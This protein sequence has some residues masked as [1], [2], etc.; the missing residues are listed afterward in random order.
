MRADTDTGGELAVA[1]AETR[2]GSARAGQPLSPAVVSR[3]RW[4]LDALAIVWLAWVYDIIANLAPLRQR[5]AV[6][7]ALDVLHL[8]RAL[9]LDP[10]LALNRWLASHHTLALALSDYYDNAHFIVTL[11]LL[12]WLWWRRADIYRPLRNALVLINVLG[13]AVFWLYP[14]APPRMLAGFSDVV[15]DSHAFGSWHTG[16]LA[17]A[18][19]Q[20]AAM[21]S[22]HMAWAA[23]CALVIWRLSSS[24]WMRVVA[25]MYP[26]LTT[27]AVLATGNHFLLDIFAGLLTAALAVGLAR[28]ADTARRSAGTACHKLVTKSRIR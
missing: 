3:P 24:A 15:A 4:W 26:C 25:V 18:A 19:N 16:S 13:L 7:H 6:G 1:L 17:S 12:G 11:G 21:P 20:L 5:A 8:E 9:H 23:W 28:S 10:E 27:V 22:L 2:V 14:V